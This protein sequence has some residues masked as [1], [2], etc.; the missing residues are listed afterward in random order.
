ME[1]NTIEFVAYSRKLLRVLQRIRAELDESNTD[2]AKILL[3]ELL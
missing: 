3:D 2:E 1:E